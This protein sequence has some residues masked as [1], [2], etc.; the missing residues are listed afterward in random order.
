MK[1]TISRADDEPSIARMAGHSLRE[2]SGLVF[3]FGF[4][5]ALVAAEQAGRTVRERLCAV[6]VDWVAFVLAVSLSLFGV[7]VVLEK[8]SASAR[9]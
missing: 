9:Q 8:I 1:L 5:D 3:V 4:L 7:G 6:P 2:A